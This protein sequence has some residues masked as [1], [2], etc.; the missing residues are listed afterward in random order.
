MLR[1]ILLE[2]TQVTKSSIFLVTRNAGSVTTS[3]PTRTCPCSM[4]VIAYSHYQHPS[5][6]NKNPGE[7][8]KQTALTFSTIPPLTITTPS[9]LLQNAETVTS[10]STLDNPAPC[11]RLCFN[12]PIRHNFSS[13]SLSSCRRTGS[14][15]GSKADSLCASWRSEPQRLLYL[16]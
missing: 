7:K 13:T 5:T 11:S 6:L 3:V 12:I 2:S 8:G 14:V 4:N 9:L 10:R 15:S 16:R 1:L